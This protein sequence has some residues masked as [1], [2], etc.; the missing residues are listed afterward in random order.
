MDEQLRESVRK[1]IQKSKERDKFLKSKLLDIIREEIVETNFHLP[2]NEGVEPIDPTIFRAY[3]TQGGN[4]EH[5]FCNYLEDESETNEFFDGISIDT[6]ILDNSTFGTHYRYGENPKHE[7]T[8]VLFDIYD[9]TIENDI[10]FFEGLWSLPEECLE[11]GILKD[12]SY[13]D[14]DGMIESYINSYLND[15]FSY[16][17]MLNANSENV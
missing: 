5:V 10:Y 15:F 4:D 7:F 1:I 17:E 9:K 6:F 14:R 11:D 2:Y 3:R 12:R 16:Q 8:K 13:E